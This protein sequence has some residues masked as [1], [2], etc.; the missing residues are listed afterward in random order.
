MQLRE[1]AQDICRDVLVIAVARW[2]VVFL[3][4][5]DVG[6][7]IEQTLEP[8]ARFGTCQRSAGTTVDAAAEGRVL[9]GVLA[10]GIEGVGILEPPRVS[11][12]RP[13]ITI[14]VQPAPIS[15]SPTVTGTRDNRK[16]PLTGLSI[17]RHSSMKLPRR[18]RSSR[19]RR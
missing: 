7:A 2:P 19:N 6:G 15:W 4:D 9:T 16:S 10:V 12:G 8:D 11:V 14:S 13:L 5:A 18:L 17:R 1:P 3:A